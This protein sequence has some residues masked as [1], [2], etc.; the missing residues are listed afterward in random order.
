MKKK[1]LNTKRK[2]QRTVDKAIIY[3]INHG[4]TLVDKCEKTGRFVKQKDLFGLFDLVAFRYNAVC[5][6][7]VKTNQTGGCVK[8][9]ETFA[10]NHKIKGT[11]YW[12]MTWYDRKGFKIHKFNMLK[13]EHIDERNKNFKIIKKEQKNCVICQ[14]KLTRETRSHSSHNYCNECGGDIK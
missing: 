6:I 13:K 7:Q 9:I 3:L 8:D 11:H 2:G 1:K 5:F 14:V 12:V 4:W 10:L